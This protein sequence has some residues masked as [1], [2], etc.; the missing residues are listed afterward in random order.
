M[1]NQDSIQQ[2]HLDIVQW[3]Q[4]TG[5][6]NMAIDHTTVTADAI[7]EALTE[8]EKNW[9]WIDGMLCNVGVP[10]SE[11]V[12]LNIKQWVELFINQKAKI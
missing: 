10:K 3:K 4:Y 8:I 11:Q 2:K 12:E 9:I 7:G 1:T 6:N 5:N